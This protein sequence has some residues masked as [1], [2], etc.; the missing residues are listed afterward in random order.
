MHAFFRHGLAATNDHR[1][2]CIPFSTTCLTLR[3]IHRERELPLRLSQTQ[4]ADAGP[5]RCA[6][7]NAGLPRQPHGKRRGCAYA[8]RPFRAVRQVMGDVLVAREV[9][10]CPRPT[11]KPRA[12]SAA[13]TQRQ[14]SIPT[15][16]SHSN[17]ASGGVTTCA[18]AFISG[19]AP[20][21][22]WRAKRRKARVAPALR[23]VLFSPCWH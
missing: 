14:Q 19:C 22:G 10:T 23:H 11:H 1:Q 16:K 21:A 6:L 13:D 3:P 9:C 2:E 15:V 17:S 4:V 7:A 8:F 5:E 18:H 20:Q 12:A